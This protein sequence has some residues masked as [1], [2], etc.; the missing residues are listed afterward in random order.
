MFSINF[1]FNKISNNFSVINYIFKYFVLLRVSFHTL[2]SLWG[3][4]LFIVILNQLISGTMLAFS[5][6]NETMLVALSREEENEEN[7]YADDFFWLHERGVDVIMVTAFMHL[8]KKLFLNVHDVEQ[9]YAWKS[10]VFTFL[11]IQ[12][13]VFTGL[14]LCCT[15]LSEIT[16]VIA[17][18]A[19]HTFC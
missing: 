5:L 13:T 11:M 18:N 15:H 16:L 3:F 8:F 10:G 14:V 7:N 9:E 12:L 6:M 19:L 4:I 2:G 17:A 1:S